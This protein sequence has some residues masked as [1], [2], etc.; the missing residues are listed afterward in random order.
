MMISTKMVTDLVYP[1]Y[2]PCA[3]EIYGALAFIRSQAYG[4][5]KRL[6]ILLAP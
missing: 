6:C 4:M 2:M 3:A 1:L 5:N